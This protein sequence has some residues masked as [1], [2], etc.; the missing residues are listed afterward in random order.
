MDTEA[1]FLKQSREEFLKP[2]EEEF[3]DWLLGL[4]GEDDIEI[5]WAFR[6]NN[7]YQIEVYRDRYWEDYLDDL[8]QAMGT[9]KEDE[10]YRYE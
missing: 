5:M 3:K 7:R 1:D 4:S 8:E 6:D 2:T 10:K 9:L